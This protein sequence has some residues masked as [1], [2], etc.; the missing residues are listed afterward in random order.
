V[1]GIA[2]RVLISLAPA[3]CLILAGEALAGPCKSPDNVTRVT[4]GS[5][6]L[7]IHTFGAAAGNRT[8]VVFIHGDGTRG[9]PS[10][11]LDKSAERVVGGG[12]TAVALIRPGYY[13]SHDAIST[14]T[15]YRHAG[16]GYRDGIIAAVAAAIDELK[17]HHG[18][19]RVVLVGH[20]GGAAISGVILGRYPG[21]ADAAV[22]AACPCNIGKW[23]SMR[24]R[25]QWVNSLSPHAFVKAM[26]KKTEVVALTGSRDSNT[27]PEL[28][29]DYVSALNRRGI[30][31][32]FVE[33]VGAGHSKVARSEAFDGAIARL[34]GRH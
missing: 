7:V 1:R 3:F 12:V 2:R 25:G 17:G 10:D 13:D 20:S 5:E 8:L 30:T 27:R 11:Y 9:G 31:A 6:C 24:G 26:P 33:V 34:A 4:G 15:S 19:R 29:R 23:R 16:D 28:A 18:A 21:L 32:I 22:L 14:G